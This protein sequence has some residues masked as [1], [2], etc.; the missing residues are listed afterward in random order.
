MTR[1]NPERRVEIRQRLVLAVQRDEALSAI[2]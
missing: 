1:L 2:G